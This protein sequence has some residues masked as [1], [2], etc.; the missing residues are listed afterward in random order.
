MARVTTRLAEPPPASPLSN[1]TVRL[2]AVL[3]ALS[4]ALH[5]A[6]IYTLFQVRSSARAQAILLAEEIEAAR[7]ST[8]ELRVPLKLPVP[9]AAEV[10]I[11]KTIQVPLD[12]TIPLDTT[13]NVP[14]NTPFGTYEVP[15]PIK[16]EVPI[17]L[18]APVAI[19][20]TV[21]V[22]TTVNLDSTLPLALPVAETPLAGYLDRLQA[23][24]LAFADQL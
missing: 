5:A 11:R 24:L 2:L 22:S 7:G 18:T 16:G 10:P 3:L 9:I 23:A 8:M 19:D 13:F 6:T 15:V 1:G 14:L 17:K 4:L 20:E 21:T 12:T